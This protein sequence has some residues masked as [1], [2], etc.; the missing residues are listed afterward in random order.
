MAVY[1]RFLCKFLDFYNIIIYT[2]NH[3]KVIFNKKTKEMETQFKLIVST[4]SIQVPDTGL[5]T[6]SG[7]DFVAGGQLMLVISIIIGIT[8]A[9]AM[10]VSLIKQYRRPKVSFG[11]S[12]KHTAAAKIF[13]T[14]MA[15]G[16]V[17]Y[18]SNALSNQNYNT[19][20]IEGTGINF[21]TSG[22][23]TVEADLD[24]DN[25]VFC[26]VDSVELKQPLPAGYELSMSAT[27]LR[28]ESDENVTIGALGGDGLA[29]NT[30]G[31]MIEGGE[32]F[33]AIP[34]EMSVIKTANDAANNG[35][36]T[37]V[38]YCVKLSPEIEPGAYVSTISYS[39]ASKYSLTLDANGG[40]FENEQKLLSPYTSATSYEFEI[41]NVAPTAPTGYMFR[42]W[43]L[44]G[45]ETSDIYVAGDKITVTELEN[46]LKAVY[47]MTIQG[48]ANDPD[49]CTDTATTVYDKRDGEAY[50]IQRLADGRCW[51]LDNLRLDPTN[52]A[53]K[54]N[55]TAENTNA[56]A[57][58]LRYFKNGGGTTNDPYATGG[59]SASWSSSFS[60]PRIDTTN[61]D[62]ASNYSL[63]QGE[64]WKMGVYYNYC[65]ASAGSYCYGD[66]G[67]SEGT[68]VGDATEDICPAGWRMPT[69]GENGEYQAL[70][71]AITGASGT[72]IGEN[73]LAF[74]NAF[75]FSAAGYIRD[76]QIKSVN[77]NGNIWSST[78]RNNTHMFTLLAYYT[79]P[80]DLGVY[81]QNVD[82]MS[83]R[84]T[85][86]S[87]RCVMKNILQ[88]QNI[89]TMQDFNT[90]PQEQEDAIKASMPTYDG[91]NESA[92]YT[93]T[94]NRDGTEYHIAKLA[95]DNVWL[96]DNLALDLTDTTVQSKLTS[97]TTNASDT[98]LSY[99]ISGGRA[100][101]DQYPTA[102]VDNWTF[103][104][105][106][107][108]APL[109]D[110]TSKD[111]VPSD[112]LPQAG[113]WK[114]GGYYNFCAAS[115]GSYC[116]GD[117]ENSGTPSGD[118]TEDICPKGWRMPTGGASGEYRVLAIAII[119]TTG[120]SDATKINNFR[121]ALK[122]PLSGRFDG[123]SA[124]D[125]GS[126]GRFWSSTRYGN[127][128][129]SHL[130]SGNS[131][132]DTI[133]VDPQNSG[134]RY[135]GYSVRCIL[136]Y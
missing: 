8:L 86:F 53:T 110:M 15:I 31:Y 125:Q 136:S 19:E 107:Y 102:G 22:N 39:M 20:A 79:G 89:T 17:C 81:P 106:S 67:R 14:I 24:E 116:Y 88:Q 84:L 69:G 3:R 109:I 83:V 129:M 7:T 38:N 16:L 74:M 111:V 34:T 64:N 120:F 26:G 42:G 85:G 115:A 59:V 27:T 54:A 112:S 103:P 4:D 55:I 52:P 118:A 92:V 10:I 32:T 75:R 33:A 60:E 48:T 70:V 96:L 43:S 134:T 73:T 36:L 113:G 56:S 2:I 94:D 108:S 105:Y 21:T 65:A 114:V 37:K 97:A 28:S 40:S 87:V 135:G 95:D 124:T 1:E 23:L 80:N 121:N 91:T 82:E 6:A 68:P 130:Y 46:T 78:K 76:T 100:N 128:G 18:A 77:D 122:T 132:M 104:G 93:V 72:V 47:N 133:I 66:A 11:I 41:P 127:S 117:G 51:L 25:S 101:G 63:S 13:S 44:T 57:E 50:T 49:L 58:T 126:Y 5:N 45:D 62:T 35:D 131:G 61:K 119:G 90:L 98:T 71:T 123:I 99:L 30:W 9:I 12:R 29:D